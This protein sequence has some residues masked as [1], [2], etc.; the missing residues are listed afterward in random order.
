MRSV[1]SADVDIERYVPDRPDD[2]GVWVRVI[3]GP[4]NGPGEESFDVLV[5]TPLWLRR[6]VAEQGPQ[7]GRYHL[8]LEP[9]NLS[10]AA[11]HLRSRFEAEEAPDWLALA[12]RLARFGHWEFEDCRE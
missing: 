2:D 8:I 11:E 7:D 1:T 5:C 6:V 10:L 3:A 12:E 9:M 4:A